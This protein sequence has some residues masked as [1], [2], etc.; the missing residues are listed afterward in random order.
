VLYVN[1]SCDARATCVTETVWV[2]DC[3]ASTNIVTSIFVSE[4]QVFEIPAFFLV[5][6]LYKS[7]PVKDC[8]GYYIYDT[9]VWISWILWFPHKEFE[10][11]RCWYYWKEVLV[12]CAFKGASYGM[13]SITSFMT[14]GSG[15]QVIKTKTKLN[16]VALVRELIR[17]SDRRLLVK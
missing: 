7:C 12:S 8:N 15:I 13:V 6:L 16:S 11:P 5:D 3:N 1:Y 10:R 2:Y 14:I 4:L 17:P 9:G